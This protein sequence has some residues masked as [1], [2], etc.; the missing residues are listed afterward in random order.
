M[1]LAESDCD[2]WKTLT[3][4][5]LG[6]GAVLSPTLYATLTAN[7]PLR[8]VL[9]TVGEG[10]P[11]TYGDWSGLG[12]VYLD[13]VVDAYDGSAGDYAASTTTVGNRGTLQFKFDLARTTYS[14]SARM[15]NSVSGLSGAFQ[16]LVR[17]KGYRKTPQM[18]GDKLSLLGVTNRCDSKM[19]MRLCISNSAAVN[20]ITPL[21]TAPP[22]PPPVSGACT[23]ATVLCSQLDKAN[24]VAFGSLQRSH[25]STWF[26]GGT[27]A[28]AGA[29]EDMALV[30]SGGMTYIRQRYIPIS[31]GSERVNFRVTLSKPGLEMYQTYKLYFEP[32]FEAVKGGK[33]PGLAGG[34][35]PTGGS[36]R[37]DGF[38]ARFMWRG[39][40]QLAI[41]AYHHD[42]PSIYG[43]DIHAMQNGQR[44]QWTTGRWY[45]IGER[46][47]MN[48]NGG[49]KNGVGEIWI[50]GVKMASRTNLR[51]RV[52]S[53]NDIDMWL[54]SSFYGGNDPSW[55]P[56]KT[57]YVRVRDIRVGPTAQS[58]GL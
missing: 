16:E 34:S 42:R 45:E 28:G 19:A 17:S 6:S 44:F 35:M 49:T 48:S 55:A 26:T 43:E 7:Q 13:G 41:Y 4:S 52:D 5:E 1:D 56:S 37:T 14:V 2:M 31:K 24:P 40:N 39:S 57:T 54:Y 9:V 10:Q 11:Q 38:S 32:G 8:H 25:I 18:G 20:R 30:R 33:L 51:W 12:R 36:T 3:A 46:I 27:V 15:A 50:D 53:T 29:L 47:K 22:S 58:V 23:S 21:P